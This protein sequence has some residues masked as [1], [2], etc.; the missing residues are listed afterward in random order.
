MKEFFSKLSSP[1]K[2]NPI[3]E[4]DSARDLTEEE[5]QIMHNYYRTIEDCKGFYVPP[6]PLD[7]KFIN[8]GFCI[9]KLEPD[10]DDV[11]AAA[12]FAVDEYN[13]EKITHRACGHHS[14]TLEKVLR[15]NKMFISGRVYY[16]TLRA[17]DKC[18]YEAEVF[19]DRTGS[20]GDEI[21]VLNSFGHAK[22]YNERD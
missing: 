9:Y 19:Y 11:V 5:E 13:N 15:A 14:L 2:V 8:V 20:G 3:I 10:R 12:E 18:I 6:W 17:T 16:I 21:P 7:F 1:I 4:A 22:Y